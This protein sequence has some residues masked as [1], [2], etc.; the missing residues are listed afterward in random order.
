M[1][2]GLKLLS[3]VLTSAIVLTGCTTNTSLTEDT[4]I[5]SEVV[6]TSLQQIDQTKWQY[7]AEDNVYWQINISYCENPTAEEYQSLGIF[8]PGDYMT[9]TDNGD[10]TFTCEINPLVEVAGYTAETAPMVIPVDTPGYAAMAAPTDYVSDAATYTDA[11]FIYVAAGCR[12]RDAGAP[13]GVTDLKAA[14]RYIRY[15]EGVIPGSTDRVFTFGMSGGGA[16]SALLGATGDSELYTPYLEAIG[17]VQG[18]SDAV[19][20]SM[21]WCPITSLDY[22]NE[23]YE[24]NLGVTRTD[25]D[26][27][28]QE[29]SDNMAAAYATYLNQL[30]LQDEN[31]NILT[32]VESENG[33]Y[34]A[35]SYYDYLKSV[36]EDSLNN[37]L[38]DTI[39]PYSVQ[40]VGFGRGMGGR[41]KGDLPDL[42][43]IDMK[44]KQLPDGTLPEGEI[45]E[46]YERDG[47]DRNTVSGGITL[48]GTYETVQDYIDALNAENIW[49][50]YD[51]ESNTATITS[52]E[53]FVKACKVA[54]KNIGAFDDLDEA[55]GENTLF[56][57]GDGTGAHFDAIMAEL[58][59]NNATYG[60]AYAEDLAKTDAL[61]N[62]VDYRVNM[63]NPMY[64]LDDYYAGY[65]SAAVAP[66]WRIRTGINQGDTALTT[67]VNLALALENYGVDVDFE[68][69]WGQ[70]HVTAERTGDSTSNFIAWVNECLN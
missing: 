6:V 36:I 35:G 47:I 52:I 61:G 53:D 42:A 51:S 14:I 43:D 11:G 41:P 2:Y 49:V 29:L 20:G 50:S 8:I 25:L 17:A 26:E 39:F 65:Q 19:T 15:N 1:H 48:S 45:N 66:Y 24:W 21:A 40:S 70:G 16:Q 3:T 32:L 62:T 46:F 59:K 57:Y 69:V 64:Y 68:T 33:I 55:Q 22:A 44:D 38:Q 31:G 54:S 10:G 34:Q 67:E 27:D 63:Y 13:A 37:F 7:N 56:G 23:A 5:A 9:S 60:E 30:G 4:D 12:G 18:V 28:M 58:L